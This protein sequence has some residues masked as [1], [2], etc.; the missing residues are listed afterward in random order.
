MRISKI[1]RQR[2]S[3]GLMDLKKLTSNVKQIQDD[4]LKE[5]LTLTTMMLSLISNEL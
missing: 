2:L 5:I 4:V 3:Y 1:I